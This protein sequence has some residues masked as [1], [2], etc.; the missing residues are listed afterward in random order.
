MNH[1]HLAASAL[2]AIAS[3]GAQAATY[4]L[5]SGPFSMN[6]D[7]VASTEFSDV[8]NFGFAAVSG[9]I[10]GSLTEYKLA[11]AIDI[12]WGDVPALAIHA[13]FGGTGALL[14]SYGDPGVPTGAF[15]I[16]DLAVPNQ[17]SMVI[18]G[19]AIGSG[20]NAFQPGLRGSYDL[21][22]AAQ[23]VPEPGTLAMLLAGLGVIGF[24]GTRRKL[25]R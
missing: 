6:V 18:N 15:A 16:E 4:D 5:S 3:A 8:Y 24:L 11:N 21:S 23:P 7:K 17:F 14:A 12:D 25:E 2:L 9:F 13:G 1:L 10:S 19:R 22:V 20:L